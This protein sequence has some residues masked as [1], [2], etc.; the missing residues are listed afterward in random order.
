MT[1]RVYDVNTQTGRIVRERAHVVVAPTVRDSPPTHPLAF[2]SCECA[3]CPAGP[4]LS[5]EPGP[6]R[7]LLERARVGW[8]RF[9]ASLQE[10]SD[11]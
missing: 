1:I 6:S 7:D 3:L 5:Q 2:P 9:A 8:E 11:D 10:E 4:R